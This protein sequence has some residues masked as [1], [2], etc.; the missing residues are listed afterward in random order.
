[1]ILGVLVM[2]GSSWFGILV[3]T[4]G[5]CSLTHFQLFVWTVTILSLISG[6][7]FG[8]WIHGANN[9]LGFKI[10]G[11]V[12]GLLGISLG[13]AATATAVKATKDVTAAPNIA[14]SDAEIDPPRL[15]QIFLLEEGQF[16]DKAI[17]IGKYQNFIVTLVL[18]VAYVGLSI[19]QVVLHGGAIGALPSFS[20]TFLILVGINQAGYVANKLPSQAG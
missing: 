14:A 20:G 11:Q 2:P 4:R 17:D 5:R 12:L 13:S 19:H 9:P 7:F 15:V 10:P 3:D 1:M 8:R 18:V 6:F 16:A